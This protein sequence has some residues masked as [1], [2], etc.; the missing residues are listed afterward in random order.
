[1]Q[2]NSITA[3]KQQRDVTQT[4]LKDG[5]VFFVRRTRLTLTIKVSFTIHFHRKIIAEK[6]LTAVL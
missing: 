5:A 1:M 6:R 4:Q 2:Q 3:K